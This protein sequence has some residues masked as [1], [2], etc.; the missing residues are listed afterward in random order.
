MKIFKSQRS[1]IQKR[2]KAA[3]TFFRRHFSRSS[4]TPESQK[5]H[6]DQNANAGIVD[7]A[8]KEENIQ[9][10]IK[11]ML[12]IESSIN[13]EYSKVS[14][15]GPILSQPSVQVEKPSDE[16]DEEATCFTSST[17]LDDDDD[18]TMVSYSATLAD[19]ITSLDGEMTVATL[20]HCSPLN[21]NFPLL[22]CAFVNFVDNLGSQQ[23]TKEATAEQ[24]EWERLFLDL[25]LA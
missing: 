25:L 13:N 6:P 12:L 19:D 18:S 22:L 24:D 10:G 5:C 17:L 14:I 16:E 7:I 2:P 4:A 23:P 9:H 15:K 8:R 1:S 21:V 3:S 20:D 11:T